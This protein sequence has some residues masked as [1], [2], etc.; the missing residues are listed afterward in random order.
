MQLKKIAK[1][2]ILEFVRFVNDRK[3]NTWVSQNFEAESCPADLSYKPL[4]S[5]IVPTYNT[6]PEYF[7]AM[8]RSVISQTYDNW[9][10]I[11]VDDFSPN[12]QTRELIRAAAKK[13]L[14]IRY[15]FLKSNHRIAAATNEGI[16]MARGEF[17]SLF[18][19]DDIL[20]PSALCEIAK[21]LN[22]NKE[23]NLIYTDEDKIMDGKHTDPL[24]KPDWNDELLRNANYI[25]HFTTIRKSVLDKFGYEDSVYDGAQDWEL[26]LRITR[27]V[28]PATIYHIAKVLYSWRIHDDSTAKSLS[29]KPYVIRAQQKALVDDLLAR[30]YEL[31]NFTVLQHPKYTGQWIV[32]KP[33]TGNEQI[34]HNLD[35]GL[36]TG[37]NE[38][39]YSFIRGFRYHTLSGHV[40]RTMRY[41]RSDGTIYE[42]ES[43]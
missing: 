40:Y 8:V 41:R 2:P 17:V 24:I 12:S 43:W 19:H 10:L 16:K 25:T 28:D 26:F 39:M 34:S 18:D 4:I 29:A 42:P 1:K 38:D 23:L 35:I 36:I 13:D 31:T 14:R 7:G 15:K 21:A 3:Y 5:V 22:V 27:R 33:K 30:G 11:L 6:D 9:E 32:K 20:W 37:V